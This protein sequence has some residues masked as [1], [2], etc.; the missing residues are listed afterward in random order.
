MYCLS[1][2]NIIIIII[3]TEMITECAY[4]ITDM[5]GTLRLCSIAMGKLILLN[6]FCVGANKQQIKFQ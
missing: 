4:I 2:D 3:I 1:V 6:C 5:A